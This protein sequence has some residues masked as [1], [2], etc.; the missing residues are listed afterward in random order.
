MKENKKHIRVGWDNGFPFEDSVLTWTSL[1]K[2]SP[3][4][5]RIGTVWLDDGWL[6]S[7]PASELCGGRFGGAP[8][9]LASIT[10][11]EAKG[12]AWTSA[13]GWTAGEAW[14]SGSGGACRRSAW[15]W[16]KRQSRHFIH[17]RQQRFCMFQVEV[18][19]PLCL[20]KINLS[21]NSAIFWIYSL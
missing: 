3:R 4:R 12:S 1:N 21:R 11:I 19:P 9:A 7:T 5:C 2:S 10:P 14:G 13:S 8:C 18:S 15:M 6:G 20:C 17:P 16:L